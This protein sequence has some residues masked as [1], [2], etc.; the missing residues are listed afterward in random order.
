MLVNELLNL[1]HDVVV[2]DVQWFGNT[3]QNHKHLTVHKMDIRDTG[4]IPLQDVEIIYHLANVAND[5]SVDISN[6]WVRVI[7]RCHGEINVLAAQQF[8]DFMDGVEVV[9][10]EDPSGN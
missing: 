10:H 7:Q 2:V 8:E 1:G 5:P 6:W 9:V 3:L 4:E